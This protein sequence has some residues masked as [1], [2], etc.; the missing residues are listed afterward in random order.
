MRPLI[1]KITPS[2]GFSHTF[3]FVFNAALPL[4]VFL[5]VRIS[6]VQLALSLIL[7]SK[8]RMLAVRP[9]FWVANIRANAI[10]MIVGVSVL[11]FMVAAGSSEILQFVWAVFY[12]GWLIGVKPRGETFWVSA[13][14]LIGFAAGLMAV[15]VTWDHEPL[16]LLVLSVGAV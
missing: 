16:G 11:A 5:L 12:A 14:A 15:F 9:R 7:L 6:F 10:D 4:L 8:W 2:R 1:N 3:Y 13:Q